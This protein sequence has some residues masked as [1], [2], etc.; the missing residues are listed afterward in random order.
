M[1]YPWQGLSDPAA[2]DEDDVSYYRYVRTELL[3]LIEREPRNVLEIGCAGGATGGELKR[4]YP[5]AVVTGVEMHE[6]AAAV[7]RTH[8]DRVICQNVEKLEFDANGIKQGS[9]DTVLLA[10]V[11][12]H[13]YD[14]WHLLVRLKPYLTKDAQVIASIPNVRNLWLITKLLAG[15][16]EYEEA[17]LLDI[18]HIRFFTMKGIEELFGQTGY[19]ITFVSRTVDKRVPIALCEPEQ[20]VNLT[21]EGATIT[22][23]TRQDLWEYSALQFVVRAVPV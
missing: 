23:A 3:S 11:L 9:V 15:K 16:W 18:T 22:G 8:L 17:G 7:A 20:R 2:V 21:L 12:E 10:D 5:S 4:H 13:L 6:G 1:K 19:S 14:P